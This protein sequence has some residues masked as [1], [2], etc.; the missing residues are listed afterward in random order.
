MS[1]SPSGKQNN[2]KAKNATTLQGYAWWVTLKSPNLFVI[3][4]PDARIINI[5]SSLGSVTTNNTLKCTSYKCSKAALNMATKCFAIEFP[6]LTF[7]AMH[8]GWVQTDMGSSKN[9]SPPVPI[10]E[11]AKKVVN[12]AE[13]VP[14]NKSGSFWSFDG[15]ELSY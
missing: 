6:N 14:L 5:S 9:R 2:A 7:V 11:S 3:L 10:E 12:V 8:P 1:V 13:K 4:A 15:S